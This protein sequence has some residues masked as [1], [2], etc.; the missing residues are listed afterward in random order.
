MFILSTR[1][2]MC[3]VF[4][5]SKYCC[6]LLMLWILIEGNKESSRPVVAFGHGL[7]HGSTTST[8]FDFLNFWRYRG[9]YLSGKLFKSTHFVYFFPKV[10]T[11]SGP[12]SL[13]HTPID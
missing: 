8:S 12:P 13:A 1:E 7:G 2:N 4:Y 11:V 6:A 10:R 3:Y 5:L 9:C